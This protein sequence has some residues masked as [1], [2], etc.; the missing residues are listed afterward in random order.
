MEE[1]GKNGMMLMIFQEWAHMMI[2]VIQQN[3]LQH[4]M[5]GVENHV[6][7]DHILQEKMEDNWWRNPISYLHGYQGA[8]CSVLM[9]NDANTEQYFKWMSIREIDPI[10]TEF[11]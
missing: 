7:Q 1:Y 11:N 5:D 4:L 9:R 3:V 10:T 6:M 2:L 8:N